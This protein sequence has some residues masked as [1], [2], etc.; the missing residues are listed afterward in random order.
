MKKQ[1]FTT[2]EF[3]QYFGHNRWTVHD[4]VVKGEIK[5]LK[6]GHAWQIPASE[7]SKWHR[8]RHGK[9]FW[10]ERKKYQK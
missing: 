1:Y 9:K 7:L 3:A 6:V 4:K 2:M 10:L 5:A 8:V